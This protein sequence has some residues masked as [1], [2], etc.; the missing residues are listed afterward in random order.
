M[1]IILVTAITLATMAVNAQNNMIAYE[2]WWNE[3]DE[4]RTT[5]L[6][7]APANSIDITASLTPDQL[8][9]GYHTMHIRLKDGNGFWSTVLSRPFM[10]VDE[11]NVLLVEGEYWFDEEDAVRTTFSLPE[12]QYVTLAID[13]NTSSLALGPHR[14]HYRIRNNDH[15]WSAVISR[16]FTVVNED[17]FHLVLM[18]Y[19]SDT[20]NDPP[21]DLT[22]MPIE[23][24]VVIWDVLDD[25]EFCTWTTTGNTTVHF[26]LKD[27]HAQWSSVISRSI[28]ID[29]VGTAPDLPQISGA[30]VVH[31][32]T[33]YTYYASSSGGAE[34]N[35]S[36]PPDWETLQQAGDSI[37]VMSSD[38]PSN[39]TIFVEGINACGTGPTGSFVFSVGVGHQI[40]STG[41]SIHPNPFSDHV[42]IMLPAGS[43]A[44]ISIH[45]A[46]GRTV[47]SMELSQ[48]DRLRLEGLAAG[49]YTA[50]IR[51]HSG[52]WHKVQLVKQ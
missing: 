24:H 4:D 11:E 40:A 52:E 35:W 20:A 36:F 19:W 7:P 1:R 8:P 48:S 41:I 34:Y 17:E 30:S 12:Q 33:V 22:I 28:D 9:Y 15:V 29:V 50:V 25:I 16:P 43:S 42:S 21:A 2:Y 5:V 37:V 27:D 51:T 10:I 49:T 23:P 31:P 3:Q 26:Q 47:S 14:I 38:N 39:G 18:R 32:N 46:L 13:P 44:S 45:D 6:I